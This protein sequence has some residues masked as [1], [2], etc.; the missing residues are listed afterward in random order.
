MVESSRYQRR[1]RRRTR[2]SPMFAAQTFASRDS[3]CSEEPLMT[4]VRD[5][6]GRKTK[7]RRDTYFDSIKDKT[8]H[9]CCGGS[10]GVERFFLK[11]RRACACVR[12]C[13]C[14]QRS[15][16]L[17]IMIY[18]TFFTFHQTFQQND[19]R[20]F[21]YRLKSPI[22]TIPGKR[23]LVWCFH[24][25]HPNSSTSDQAAPE[26][27]HK[28]SPLIGQTK[29]HP[30]SERQ[31]KEFLKVKPMNHRRTTT[32]SLCWSPLFS[33]IHY[34]VPTQSVFWNVQIFT[35]FIQGVGIG[36]QLFREETKRRKARNFVEFSIFSLFLLIF[37]LLFMH[38]F[39]SSFLSSSSSPPLSLIPLISFPFFPFDLSPLCFFHSPCWNPT[40]FCLCSLSLF[41]SQ[42]SLSSLSRISPPLS[43]PDLSLWH[44]SKITWNLSPPLT[45]F[46]DLHYSL[47][48]PIS[49]PQHL[50]DT[51][52]PFLRSIQWLSEDSPRCFGPKTNHQRKVTMTSTTLRTLW[53]PK[54]LLLLPSSLPLQK[55]SKRQ[56]ALPLFFRLRVGLDLL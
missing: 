56:I 43:P 34:P 25:L 15:L 3:K 30:W 44:H 29:C 5:I 7:Q 40:F 9:L 36:K 28:M 35:R 26:I 39:L 31:K 2:V 45:S 6:R 21:L 46:K 33:F 13:M 52:P 51:S 42:I 48:S 24:R 49:S 23:F 12:V 38:L 17:K 4:C 16:E 20:R 50:E 10:K 32:T 37:S 55:D 19:L 1:F 27:A 8:V 53:S 41:L 54:T 22:R 47:T 11:G 18:R 14:V